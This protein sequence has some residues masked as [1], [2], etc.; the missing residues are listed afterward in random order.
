MKAIVMTAAGSPDVLQL[1][2]VPDPVIQQ[3]RD[4]L[5]RLKAAGVNPIDT[6]LR[7]RGTFYPDLMPA[8][9]GC[10]GAGIVEAIG[11]GVENFQVGDA[12]YFCQGGLGSRGGNYAEYTVV[13][14]RFVAHKPV[15]LTFAEAAA[16][17]LVLITAWEALH[18][19]A[20]LQPGQR[21]LI[22]AGAGGVGHVAIQ[23][24]QI[25]G[26]S[27]A[28]TVGSPEKAAF[29]QQLGATVAILYQQ[30]DFV[31]AVMHW[32]R[33]EGVDVVLD[34]VGSQVFGRSFAATRLYG[35]VV[36][37]LAPA[38]DTDWKTAR[39]RNLSL[40]FELMLTPM[41]QHQEAAQQHQAK[42]LA[43]CAQLCDRGQLKPY[44][45]KAF[46][47]EEAVA[48]HHLLEAGSMIG[49]IALLINP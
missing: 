3:P 1:Q 14:E 49:K 29:A 34:T 48:A 42:I 22:H 12:V 44:L 13:D 36:T 18:D 23:L 16:A 41:L 25:H 39:D 30:Q 27:I 2:T 11:S 15:S 43:D 4:L 5:I 10:D 24:A 32:S 45:T 6:K 37:L 47:L 40:S 31:E 46:P 26:A 7:Q 38:A 33:G 17:P 21:V 8:I 20:K 19:R 28:T 35:Q 9:L